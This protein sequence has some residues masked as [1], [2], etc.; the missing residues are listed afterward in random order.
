M[1]LTYGPD[2]KP[3]TNNPAKPD[4]DTSFNE[5]LAGSYTIDDALAEKLGRD[6]KADGGGL[7]YNA[8]KTLME[9]T[10]PEWEH[11]LA[12]VTTQGSKKY[13][14][15]NWERGMDWSI[16]VGCMKRHLTKFL[17]GER[18]DG[19]EFDIEAG[20]TG[21]HH[22]AM[23]AWNALALMSYDLRGIGNNDLPDLPK[24]LLAM[25][26]AIGAGNIP[27]ERPLGATHEK[28]VRGLDARDRERMSHSKACWE[29]QKLFGHSGLC[30]CPTKSETFPLGLGN[31]AQNHSRRCKSY[32]S[33]FGTGLCTC[34]MKESD[35]S[36]MVQADPG[37]F[38]V[39]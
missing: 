23:V 18:Y 28:I 29:T 17:V 3:V 35:G 13:E 27:K 25:V 5:V 22:L 38:D 26:N 32:Q 2:G 12:D 24:E 4:K 34:P 37:H 9:L 39:V 21:C 10:P 16:M 15:R 19:D 1:A 33:V 7:R 30:D 11:A 14:K 6:L 8:G 31:P 20:T 36:K